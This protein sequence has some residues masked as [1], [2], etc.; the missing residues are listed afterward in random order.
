MNSKLSRITL[1]VLGASFIGGFC[2]GIYRNVNNITVYVPDDPKNDAVLV[3]VVI[4]VCVI[5]IVSAIQLFRRRK[6]LP[7]IWKAP[8]T[9]DA[10][11]RLK[12]TLMPRSFNLLTTPRIPIS[13]LLALIIAFAPFRI[14][15]QIIGGLDQAATNNAWG[16][17]SYG[18]AMAAH[19]MDMLIIT[20][21]AALLL[22]IVMVRRATPTKL[23]S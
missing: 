9:K 4:A 20:Y 11:A 3:H 15:E 5:I 21:V 23:G 22:H 6:Q 1:G 16:G 7:S 10:F 13:F 19:Y 17:P 8:F 12:A 14:G 18:G 2:Y